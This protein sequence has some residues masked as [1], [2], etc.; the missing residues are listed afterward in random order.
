M[1]IILKVATLAMVKKKTHSKFFHTQ[2]GRVFISHALHEPLARNEQSRSEVRCKIAC[3]FSLH[4]QGSF[5][6]APAGT[7]F[8]LT[9]VF[10]RMIAFTESLVPYMRIAMRVSVS[11]FFTT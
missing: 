7:L 9:S 8:G 4:A 10:R 3:F 5:I 1:D 11:P 6:L 2:D